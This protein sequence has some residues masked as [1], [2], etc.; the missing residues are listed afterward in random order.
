MPNCLFPSKLNVVIKYVVQLS[1]GGFARTLDWFSRRFPRFSDD[2]TSHVR[3]GSRFVFGL[4]R[5]QPKRRKNIC[6][7][8]AYNFPLCARI[9]VLIVLGVKNQRTLR[10]RKASTDAS[11]PVVE[12][13]VP[14]Q[15]ISTP[16]NE[17]D[18]LVS[19][20]QNETRKTPKNVAA[21]LFILRAVVSTTFF[22]FCLGG[23]QS[24]ASRNVALRRTGRISTVSEHRFS[25][26]IA[27]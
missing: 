3:G 7:F 23:A 13:L 8:V 10:S 21:K 20:R 1:R 11:P 18:A 19:K 5:I 16:P 24:I 15:F 12:G 17:S 26:L 4:R 6:T 27:W 25:A 9:C 2:F 22:R 14:I